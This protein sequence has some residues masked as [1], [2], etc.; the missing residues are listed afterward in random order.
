MGESPRLARRFLDLLTPRLVRERTAITLNLA[1]LLA[2]AGCGDPP[3]NAPLSAKPTNPPRT[4]SAPLSTLGAATWVP[5]DAAY[6]SSVHGMG[7]LLE[8]IWNSRAIQRLR[9]LPPLRSALD[10]FERG[11]VAMLVQARG[12]APLL[13]RLLG[14]VEQGLDGELFLLAGADTGPVVHAAGQVWS[15][16]WQAELARAIHGQPEADPTEALADAIERHGDSLWM[17]PVVLGMHVDDPAQA[18]AMADDLA[19]AAQGLI[20]TQWERMQVGGGSF[21]ATEL[22]LEEIPGLMSGIARG[23]A[24]QRLPTSRQRALVRWLGQQ[25]IAIAVGTRGEYLL[26]SIGPD[27]DLLAQLGTASL[28]ESEAWA[29]LRSHHKQGLLSL[30]H[31]ASTLRF[32]G[33]APV[34]ALLDAL[35]AEPPAAPTGAGDALA[36]RA[37]IDDV[38]ALLTEL[39]AAIPEPTDY[40]S[41]SYRNRGIESFTFGEFDSGNRC[42]RPLE[43]WDHTGGSPLAAFASSPAAATAAYGRF[44]HWAEVFWGHFETLARPHMASQ[45]RRE[46]DA[47][48]E[49]FAPT[50]TALHRV[51]SEQLLPA[52][53]GTENLLVFDAGWSVEALPQVGRLATPL[54]LPRPTAV[55][56]VGDGAAVVGAF[57]NYREIINRLLDR[58]DATDEFGIGESRI[59][60]PRAEP[61]A[62]GT[63][64]DYPEFGSP[65]GL[66]PHFAVRD[67]WMA[68]SLSREVTNRVLSQHQPLMSEVVDFGAPTSGAVWI[69]IAGCIDLVAR[70]VLTL[71]EA[72]SGRRASFEAV[73]VVREVSRSL[74]SLR[75]YHSR[76]YR[77]AGT[78]ARHSWLHVDDQD[79]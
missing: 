67:D 49:A 70:G 63:A 44:A 18:D 73:E 39:N 40:V 53:E 46:F 13:D 17:P 6:F 42:D 3:S 38:G 14:F 32:S 77:E 2:L 25:P 56:K 48:A 15:E 16:I 30:T 62:G 23:L 79:H 12:E 69:D 54:S 36:R 27:Y 72:L 76:S 28:A 75:A 21:Q 71:E 29:P 19:A 61:I 52:T 34:A 11:P 8:D 68:A 50:A 59:P 26:F 7:S 64:F 55:W 10:E 47:F 35:T 78:Q 43:I 51:T 60:A 74:T 41:A 22:V 37:L 4:A 31:I 24:S 58:L 57:G 1:A 5:A 33:R 20:R 65:M 66:E 45:A 9:A